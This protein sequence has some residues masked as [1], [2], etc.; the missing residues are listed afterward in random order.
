MAARKKARTLNWP[1]WTFLKKKGRRL[2]GHPIFLA[3]TVTGN[4][5][6][7]LGALS[8][9]GAEHG[10]N[11]QVETL[12]DTLWWAVNT[13]TT[14]GA[15]NI[16]PV[17]SAGKI[18]GIILMILGSALFWCYTAI[19][20]EALIT[21]ELDDVGSELRG[22]E[23]KLIALRDLTSPERLDTTEALSRI[24]AHLRTIAERQHRDLSREGN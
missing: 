8:L 23:R 5:V 14:V 17:T 11:P 24:E 16:V 9:F 18:I 4:F 21:D 7:A 15:S 3:V 12:L 2:V 6:I 20:A 22:I 13:V 1:T 19:F 10:S